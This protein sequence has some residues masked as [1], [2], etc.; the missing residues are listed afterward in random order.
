MASL[1]QRIAAIEGGE[2]PEIMVRGVDGA[3]VGDCQRGNLGVGDEV[4]AGGCGFLEEVQD[5]GDVIDVWLENSTDFSVEPA[6]HM[7]GRFRQCHRPNVSA[8]TGGDADEGEEYRMGQPHRLV[9]REA[10]LPPLA[11]AGMKRRGI[12]VGIQQQIGVGDDHFVL[13][14]ES[15]SAA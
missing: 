1:F 15:P 4:A 5:L 14:R 2:P 7:P 11:S 6:C 10:L 8:G 13:G 3:A 9:A 12:V